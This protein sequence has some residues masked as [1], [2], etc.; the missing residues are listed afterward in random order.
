MERE[1]TATDLIAASM[2]PAQMAEAQKLAREW[3][4]KPQRS[5]H[6]P[7]SGIPHLAR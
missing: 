5:Q 6:V 1:I 2:A 7:P 3:K 4:P